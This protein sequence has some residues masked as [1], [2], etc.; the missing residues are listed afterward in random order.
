MKWSL[1]KYWFLWNKVANSNLILQLWQIK[2]GMANF[3]K[4]SEIFNSCCCSLI[5]SFPINWCTGNIHRQPCFPFPT[6]TTV[7][8]ER[9]NENKLYF[10]HWH[11]QSRIFMI[12]MRYMV[13]TWYM[14]EVLKVGLRMILAKRL[15][16]KYSTP[17]KIFFS[18]SGRFYIYLKLQ[19][20]SEGKLGFAAFGWN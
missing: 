7:L 19:K 20:T 3:C 18:F 5:P 1:W 4:N 13:C 17:W 8:F 2:S 9:E 10:S 12:C 15:R 6:G 16:N 14:V 11:N